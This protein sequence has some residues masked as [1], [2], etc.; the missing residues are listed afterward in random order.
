VLAGVAPA[1]AVT[2][3]TAASIAAL[4]PVFVLIRSGATSGLA[5]PS[6]TVP[7]LVYAIT[8][9]AWAYALLGP[10]RGAIFPVTMVVLMFGIFGA[11][12]RQMLGLGLYA[13]GAFGA[14]MAGMSATAPRV[15]EPR[16][17]IGHFILVATM[18]PAV[19]I[20]AGRLSRMRHRMRV[21]RVELKQ[22]FARIEELAT[23]DSL[24]GLVNRRHMAELLERERQ[25]S[26][27]SGHVFCIAMLDIDRFKAVN[28][29]H[30]IAV[31]D[32]MLRAFAREA[33][34]AVRVSDR[35]GRWGGESFVL[36]LSD[37]RAALARGGVERLRERIA[38][39]ALP[40]GGD[41]ARI[42]VSAGITEHHAGES[43]Q[44]TLDR[45]LHALGEA[46]AQGRDRLVA[47]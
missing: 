46:K 20:L 23:R 44:Q 43:V 31:G 12:P 15:Y 13:V 26:V 36:L 42:T 2:W 35:L 10:A 39:I 25:R 9:A 5:D 24:T 29:R 18:M 11:S 7:Q 37:T 4:L 3:W 41:V 1:R 21:Q 38:A 16:I 28:E 17:E 27:R 22:A 8:L 47:A 45:A 30:G 14:V 32:E 33:L 19:S 6:L 34:A 40:L